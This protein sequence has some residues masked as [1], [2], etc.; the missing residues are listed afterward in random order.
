MKQCLINQEKHQH[1]TSKV[2]D[3]YGLAIGHVEVRP[4]W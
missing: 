1:V 2:M 3:S 4:D